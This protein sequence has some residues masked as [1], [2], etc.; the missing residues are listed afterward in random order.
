V[1]IQDPYLS[2]PGAAATIAAKGGHSWD[3][4][5]PDAPLDK[6]SP[7][8][9]PKAL[10][11]YKARLNNVDFIKKQQ[12][13]VTNYLALIYAAIIWVDRSFVI[14][15]VLLMV[16]AGIAGAVGIGLLIKFQF[17]LR[18][19][20]RG[21]DKATKYCFTDDQ[22]SAEHLE[23]PEDKRPFLRG[24]EVLVAHLAVCI[25]GAVIALAALW[26]QPR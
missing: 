3:Q 22:R 18:R 11:V 23:L 6:L 8:V 5:S 25:G 16:V 13:V 21:S 7:Q 26:S 2:P 4:K 10:E 20:R 24:S 12:W 9:A 15:R 17:D 1:K 19:A 14:S